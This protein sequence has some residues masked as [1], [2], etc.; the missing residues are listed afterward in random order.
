M[1]QLQVLVAIFKEH[2]PLDYIAKLKH[3]Y[4][5]GG[6]PKWLK[7]V[8]ACLKAST[9][10][11]MKSNYCRAVRAAEK[12]EVMVPS[13]SKTGNNTSKPKVTSFFPLQKL[14]GMQPT[15]TAVV[16]MVHLEEQGAD[17]EVGAENG[18]LNGIKGVTKEFIVHLARAVRD[19]QQAEKSCYHCSLENFIHEC[20]LVKASRT[21]THLNQK[22][23]VVPEKGAWTL[24]ERW[25][26]QRCPR[27]GHP[28]HRMSY[29]DSPL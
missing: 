11:K 3:D 28:R 22:E 12:E 16:Q 2:F 15:R 17:K 20:P 19:A 24:N 10:E 29:R 7:A 1:R 25:P 5:Y 6:L 26:C 9:N 23:G 8:V 18:D 27:T 14:K 4:F 21:A 13:C